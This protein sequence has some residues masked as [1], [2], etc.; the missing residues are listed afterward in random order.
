MSTPEEFEEKAKHFFKN[1]DYQHALKWFT[2]AAKV[3]K[4]NPV[5]LSN[6]YYLIL[7]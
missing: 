2:E 5:H 4:N 1:G 7:V 6:M 3:D